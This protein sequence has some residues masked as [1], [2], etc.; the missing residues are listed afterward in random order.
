MSKWDFKTIELNP[1]GQVNFLNLS[2]KQ[3]ARINE[4]TEALETAANSAVANP[5]FSN[6]FVKAGIGLVKCNMLPAGNIEYGLCQAL[7]GEESAVTAFRSHYGRRANTSKIVLGMIT[8]NP[9]DIVTPCGN[10]R[11]II[12]NELGKDFEIVSGTIEGG[13]AIVV[14]MSHYLFSKFKK[15]EVELPTKT[16]LDLKKTIL[17]CESLVNDAYSPKDI[18]PER[19]YHAVIRTSANCFIGTRD[20]MCEYHPIY[21]LRD[22]VR[23][24]RRA[25]DPYVQSVAI[26]CP[27]LG[28]GVPHV[29]YK[30]RQ[31]LME[32]NLQAELT[33]GYKKNPSVFL[34]T[35][36]DQKY[37]TNIWE[38]TMKEWLPLPFS[39][40]NFGSEFVQHLTQYFQGL[41]PYKP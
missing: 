39:P 40:R 15:R 30:D 3:K 9:G 17:H 28:G 8:M 29:M 2:E 13:M 10:C 21:A 22:A 4:Y 20:I 36:N 33:I 5:I 27:D 16:L 41:K 31:H 37:I 38:T 23:Q 14:N 11:D 32:L 34:M 1:Q 25:H 24:A 18:H 35:Y 6:Y 26:L 12:L 7:H 19:K